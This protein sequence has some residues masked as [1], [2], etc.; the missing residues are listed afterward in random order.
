MPRTNLRN[1]DTY[2]TVL[3]RIERL[4]PETRPQWGAMTP[5]QMLAHCA[6][7]QEVSNGKGLEGTP[8]IARLLKGMIRRMVLS[9][10]PL[11][12]GTRT[13]PQYRQTADKD[14]AAE[15][16]RLLHALESFLAQDETELEQRAH[17]LFG[18]MTVEEKGWGMYKHLDHHL[19]QFG[20]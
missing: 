7:V 16:Q 14:F 12:R 9:D 8:F 11:P 2:R 18:K 3:T 20:V 19:N 13:H 6:E 10:K 17:P 5:A 15:K 4:D 1:Q